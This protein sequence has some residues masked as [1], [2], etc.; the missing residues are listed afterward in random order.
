MKKK[1][2]K[3]GLALSL[4][5]CAAVASAQLPRVSWTD[6]VPK[7]ASS[8]LKGGFTRTLTV[9]AT[10]GDYATTALAYTYIGT[11]THDASHQWVL[12]VSPDIADTGSRP[13]FTYVVFR[14]TVPSTAAAGANGC[15]PVYVSATKSWTC[16]VVSGTSVTGASPTVS[17]TSGNLTL[18]ST[19]GE[20]D[21][22]T[23]VNTGLCVAGANGAKLCQLYATESITL[24]TGG[25]T[26]DSSANL[27]PANAFIESVV[28]RVTTTI[29]TAT[30]W[31]VGDPTT[32]ARFCSADSTMTANE[33]GNCLNHLKGGVSTDATGPVQVS[34][35]KLRITTTGT[36][37]AGVVRCEVFAR[38]ATP[39]TS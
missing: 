2:A 11:Q 9:D 15:S 39:P 31:A 3:I 27:L 8:T 19:S 29:T 36:P 12:L 10:Y 5:L 1:F 33:T 35:A 28:C 24:S 21:V 25:A 18:N 34:A 7:K 4:F 20:V 16:D 17:A 6:F 13:T 14:G 23:A 26:T 30:A 37:G 22:T 38:V 32:A